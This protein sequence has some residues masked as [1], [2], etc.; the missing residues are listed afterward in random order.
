MMKIIRFRPLAGVHRAARGCVHVQQRQ[1]QKHGGDRGLFGR[2]DTGQRRFAGKGILA[3]P[4]QGTD[5][6]LDCAGG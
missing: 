6:E 2:A 4:D 3:V 1:V 5:K